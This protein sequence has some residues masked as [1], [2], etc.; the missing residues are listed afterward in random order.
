M[1][2][3]KHILMDFQRMSSLQQLEESRRF[4]HR[5]ATRRSVR[6]F[7][8]ARSPHFAGFMV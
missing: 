1:K 2:P 7:S 4:M 8:P 6:F 5:M 3:H